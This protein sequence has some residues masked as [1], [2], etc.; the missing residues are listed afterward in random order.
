MWD[1]D[2]TGNSTGYRSLLPAA[3]ASFVPDT[4]RDLPEPVFQFAQTTVNL[5]ILGLREGYDYEPPVIAVYHPFSGHMEEAESVSD[6]PTD[7]KYVFRQYVTTTFMVKVDSRWV[8][9]L[10]TPIREKR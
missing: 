3:A 10:T 4:D 5:H 7:L 1:I 6:S 8:F 2:L 9:Y